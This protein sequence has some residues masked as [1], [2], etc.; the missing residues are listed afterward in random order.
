MS[1]HT[2]FDNR[3][4]LLRLV[5]LGVLTVAILT[6]VA[7]G[8]NYAWQKRF[9]PSQASPADCALAQKIIEEAQTLPADQA[10]VDQWLKEKHTQRFADMKDGYLGLQISRYEYWAGVKAT[11]NGERPTTAEFADMTKE[12]NSHC[13]KPLTIPAVRS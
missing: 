9:G 4:K 12:A 1:T 6:A 5:G 10:K 2:V 7:V 3:P 11:G 8:G 13:D